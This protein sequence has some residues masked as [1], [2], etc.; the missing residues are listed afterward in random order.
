M[1]YHIT[2]PHQPFLQS[3]LKIFEEIAPNTN[4]VILI[5]NENNKNYKCDLDNNLLLYKGPLLAET[6]DLINSENCSGVFIYWL[7]K[8]LLELAMRIDKDKPIYWRSYGP[9]IHSIIYR[10]SWESLEPETR[11]L[12]NLGLISKIPKKILNSFYYFYKGV[13]FENK[14]Y[15]RNK[16]LFLKRINF[17]GTVTNYEYELLTKNIISFK[18]PNIKSILIRPDNIPQLKLNALNIMIG[19][20][21]VHINNH[22]DVFRILANI[23]YNNAK[24]IVPLSYGSKT[25]AKKI[26][27]LGEKLFSERFIPIEEYLPIEEY[28]KLSDSCH[29]FI[30]Y[31]SVQQGVANVDRFLLSGRKVYLHENSP[32]YID[33]KRQG[34]KLFTVQK[35]LTYD[36]LYN[37]QLT[38][39]DKIKNRDLLEDLFYSKNKIV[40]DTK[41]I[42]TSLG[43]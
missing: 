39:D 41:K 10:D 2:F 43:G 17:I 22:A 21:S 34:I 32:I 9:D 19:H 24:L 4:K 1:I 23:G 35:D 38:E 11:K 28:N 13:Y 42:I 31:S 15:Q 36:H 30:S 3:S 14:K 16:I 37:Y 12:L 26:I 18:A 8:E 25:Y 5:T 40:A 20:S 29:S 6:V 7:N 27:K 33:R